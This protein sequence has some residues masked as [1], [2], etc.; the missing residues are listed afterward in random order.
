[1][2]KKNNRKIYKPRPILLDKNYGIGHGTGMT[3]QEWQDFADNY[4][5]RK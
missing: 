3:E 4:V 5:P 1:M 2:F